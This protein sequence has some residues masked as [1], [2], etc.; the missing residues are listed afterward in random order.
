[1]ISASA[2]VRLVDEQEAEKLAASATAHTPD[3]FDEL[4]AEDNQAHLPGWEDQLLPEHPPLDPRL[5][6]FLM[7]IDEKLDRLLAIQED[8]KA[9]QD[10]IDVRDTVDLSG[11][12]IRLM[13]GE[14]LEVGQ[15]IHIT[16]KVPEMPFGKIA[17]YGKV[18]RVREDVT[19]TETLYE[20]GIRFL[21]LSR[22][23]QE[24]IIAYTFWKQRERIRGMKTSS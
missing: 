23:E 7:Q 1:M 16:L 19:D 10:V 20:A 22:Q 21:N 4:R 18:I 14:Q 15:Y 2:E 8:E 9:C 13:M 3:L 11:T 6:R 17:V 24:A 5:T 12:G